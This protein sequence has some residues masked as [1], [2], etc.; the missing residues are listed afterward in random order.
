[1]SIAGVLLISWS[2]FNFKGDLTGN[3]FA[4][5]SSLFSAAYFVAARHIRKT[6]GIGAFSV[7]VNTIAAVLMSFFALMIHEPFEIMNINV[8][9]LFYGI[10]LVGSIC[11]NVSIGW[12]LKYV[13]A[14]VTSMMFLTSPVFSAVLGFVFFRE[15]IKSTVLFGALMILAGIAIYMWIQQREKKRLN[16]M[17]IAADE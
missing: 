5:I 15:D 9:A 1:M 2:D 6:V 10:A 14:D 17:E 11:G 4:V 8:I 7:W 12:A 13:K 16:G 3:I